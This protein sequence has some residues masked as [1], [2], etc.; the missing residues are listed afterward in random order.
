MRSDL[1]FPAARAI[2][3]DVER[4]KGARIRQ[5]LDRE[6]HGSALICAQRNRKAHAL[7]RSDLLALPPTYGQVLENRSTRDGQA[8]RFAKAQLEGF[9]EETHQA[10][11]SLGPQQFFA[12]I[13]F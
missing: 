2:I 6:V 1:A 4:P 5:G 7:R 8:A 11:P 12:Q 3:Q 9:G 10:S 13:L